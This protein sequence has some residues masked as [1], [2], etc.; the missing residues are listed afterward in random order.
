MIDVI[1]NKKEWVEL[2]EVFGNIDFYHTYDYHQLSKNEGEF[3]VLI[4]YTE[5]ETVLGLPLLIRTIENSEFKDAVSVYG[6]SGILSSGT[7]EKFNKDN[8]YKELNA[9]FKENNIISVFSRFHPIL[10][11]QDDILNGLGQITT[12][13]KVVCI[14]LTDTI[15]NQ[16]AKFNRRLKTY[17]NKSRKL[18]TVINGS[19]EEYKDIFVN[20][21]EENMRRVDAD[22]SYFFSDKYYQE[23][24]SSDDF[25]SVLKL[26]IHNETQSI[27]GAAI[28]IKTGD[29]VQYH[30]S[31]LSEDTYEVDPIKLI[32]DE[33][34]I[35]ATDEGY[36]IFN[37]GGGRGSNEDSLFRFKSGFSKDFKDFKVWKYI[38]DEEAYKSLLKNRLATTEDIELSYSGFFPAYRAKLEVTTS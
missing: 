2:L 37:L 36:K 24:L 21:Y 38:V 16:R 9:Y 26:C 8:F 13:G 30:L 31:G 6:Y 4:K 18:C 12:L 14:D 33:A 17:L 35:E 28:F 29:I 22:D 25:E 23:I 20:L 7:D 11:Y 32:I 1:K 3:P 34:R 10:E 19:V 27:I 15:E 5:G